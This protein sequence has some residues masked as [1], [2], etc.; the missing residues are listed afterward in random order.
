MEKADKPDFVIFDVGEMQYA[1]PIEYIAF[2][3]MA[4][5]Q[6]P[7]CI[8]PRM[9]AYMKCVMQMEQGLV[10]IVDLTQVPGYS[11]SDSRTTPYPLV[12]IVSYR[13]K[14]I[15]LLTD[16]VTIQPAKAEVNAAEGTIVQHRFVSS[17]GTNFIQFDVEKFYNKLEAGQV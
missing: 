7:S 1:I 2:I 13:D 9:P 5:E 4:M 16:R 10:P 8:P 11:T 14:Q 17:D 15:G 12:L 3:V 6:F